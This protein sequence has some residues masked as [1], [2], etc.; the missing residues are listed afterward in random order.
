MNVY[1]PSK[2]RNVV[3]LGHAG[4]GKTTL[5][6]TMLFESRSKKRRGSIEQRNTS[7]DYH[8][9]EHE[10]EKSVFSSLL[11]LDWRGSKINLIDTPGTADYIGEVVGPLRVADT[12]LY[13][14]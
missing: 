13:L 3:L 9:V 7:S 6:E 10:K 8:E 11:N 14:R 2:I 5:A 4:S 12:W 1:K